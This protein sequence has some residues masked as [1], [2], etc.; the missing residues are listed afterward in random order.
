VNELIDSHSLPGNGFVQLRIHDLIAKA[1]HV[2]L[3][4]ALRVLISLRAVC[5]EYDMEP[6][7]VLNIRYSPERP[8]AQQARQCELAYTWMHE[9]SD[10]AKSLFE[11][12][13]LV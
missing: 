2:H 9:G 1:A 3:K 6:K 4:E 12:E 7:T 5:I 11:I 8:S 10:V 13:Q